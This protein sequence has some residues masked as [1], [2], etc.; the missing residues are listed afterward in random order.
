MLRFEEDITRYTD[1]LQQF[2]QKHELPVD[3]FAQADHLAIKCQDEFDYR[4]TVR[5]WRPRSVVG[6][7]YE[8][9]MEGQGRSI[10]AALLQESISLGP[11]QTFGSVEW[12]EIMQPRPGQE[13]AKVGVDHVEFF[14]PAFRG[15]GRFL[16]TKGIDYQF[17]H[18]PN[19]E[20][21]S[22]TDGDMEFKLN[23][24]PLRAI[25]AGQHDNR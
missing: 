2:I 10:A 20:W 14:Y 23:D 12:L 16:E 7:M 9:R 8:A 21:L 6:G 3:W 4:Q 18:N 25:V 13:G 24:M 19:H 15:L 1:T 17:Q 11:M 5:F 22:V